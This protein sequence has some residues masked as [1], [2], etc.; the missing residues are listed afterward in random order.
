[1][2]S[3][4]FGTLAVAAVMANES[5]EAVARLT[6]RAFEGAPKLLP[7]AIDRPPFFYHA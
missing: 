3:S 1:M 4:V 7:E 6:L 5:A 2:P